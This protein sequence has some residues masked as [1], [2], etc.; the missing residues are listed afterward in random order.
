[1]LS[2]D[3][4]NKE[5][6]NPHEFIYVCRKGKEE[7][8]MPYLCCI[9]QRVDVI[10]SSFFE[11]LNDGRSNVK[12]E[13]Y[14]L[15]IFPTQFIPYGKLSNKYVFNPK[16]FPHQ[17]ISFEGYED[18]EL[19]R[20]TYQTT[21]VN[22]A[23]LSMIQQEEKKRLLEKEEQYFKI[24]IQNIGGKYVD[25]NRNDKMSYN[26]YIEFLKTNDQKGVYK[27]T[28]RSVDP[29]KEDILDLSYFVEMLKQQKF[30]HQKE[31]KKMCLDEKFNSDNKENDY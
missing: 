11:D 29:S 19:I 22:L 12:L 27:R 24:F 30:I 15:P 14:L 9:I 2:R 7:L 25:M 28:R 6:E 18:E 16:T 20:F 31:F 4:V 5:F 13:N 23:G 26:V 17:P 8:V 3:V 21:D 1:M 10:S